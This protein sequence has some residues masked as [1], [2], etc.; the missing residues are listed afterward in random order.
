MK[1]GNTFAVDDKNGRAGGA[2]IPRVEYGW[3]RGGTSHIDALNAKS[4]STVES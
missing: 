1:E 3:R 4:I 2:E